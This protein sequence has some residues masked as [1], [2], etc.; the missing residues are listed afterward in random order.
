MEELKTKSVN[1][2]KVMLRKANVDYS[3][4]YEKSDLIEK[5]LQTG[6]HL[7]PEGSKSM[8]LDNHNKVPPQNMAS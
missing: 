7:V 5:V 3:D 6:A 1:D 8:L 4:C 2:L